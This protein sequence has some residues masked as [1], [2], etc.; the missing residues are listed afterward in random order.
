[1]DYL[2][3]FYK[4]IKSLDYNSSQGFFNNYN[5]SVNKEISKHVLELARHTAIRAHFLSTKEEFRMYT[6]AIYS[7]IM[8]GKKIDSENSEIRQ[9][10]T[11]VK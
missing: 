11:S 2:A 7:A 3:F 9:K 10:D 1:M 8:W 5:M 6:S 4:F